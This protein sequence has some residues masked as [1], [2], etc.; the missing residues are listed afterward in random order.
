MKEVI[1]N[2][3]GIS[4]IILLMLSE[5]FVINPITEPNSDIWISILVAIGITC[6][7][8]VAYCRILARYPG[9]NLYEILITVFGKIIGNVISIL[10]VLYCFYVGA[11]V[12]STFILFTNVVGL[13]NT[14][15]SIIAIG[16]IL[17]VIIGLKYG[18]EVMGRWSEFSVRIIYPIILLTI[19][20]MLTMVEAFNLTPVLA[21]GIQPIAKGAMEMITFPFAE[22]ITLILIFSTKSISKSK[23]IYKVFIYGLL[24]GGFVLF[25][26]HVSAYLCLGKYAYSSSYFPIYSAV[27][28][29]NIGD[30]LQRIEA[31]IAIIFIMS[32]FV[33]IAIYL[34]A[35]CKGVAVL[36]KLEDYKFIVTPLS[37]ITLVVS[38]TTVSNIM[39]LNFHIYYYNYMAILMQIIIPII[40][41]IAV[42]IKCR[43]IEKK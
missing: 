17:L 19:P 42:E 30:I 12:L 39:E 28:R 5:S 16:V 3:Q 21:D 37:I 36:L 22:V 35:G 7:I 23:S 6:L 31:I 14:P 43:F 15:R 13:I 38:L 24:L 29:I 33:K 2:R 20:L 9:K 41:L 27:S 11:L 25:C 18:L 10:Y 32:G 26:T 40:T 34:L 1:S 4:M 8:V